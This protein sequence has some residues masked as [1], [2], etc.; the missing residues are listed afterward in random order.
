MLATPEYCTAARHMAATIALQDGREV[1]VD[2]LES[3]PHHHHELH[4]VDCT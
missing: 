3:L 4:G 1:A 2:E